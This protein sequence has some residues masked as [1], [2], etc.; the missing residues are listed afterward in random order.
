MAAKKSSTNN[1]SKVFMEFSFSGSKF[2]YSGRLYPEK[3]REVGK[4][5][6][7]PMTL[8]FNGL[9]TIKGCS[10]YETSRNCWIGGPQYKSGDEYKEYWYL[11]K[12]MY[13]DMD[14]LASMIAEMLETK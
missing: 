12:E 7:I 6:I 10:Y 1:E 14:N 13:E 11:D 4:L 5:T 9:A 8:C 2:A 3:K